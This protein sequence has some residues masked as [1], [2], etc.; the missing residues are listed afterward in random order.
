M[1]VIDKFDGTEHG[2]LSNFWLCSITFENDLYPSVENAYQAAKVPRS[3]RSR[4]LQC[5]PGESK[6]ILHGLRTNTWYA[7]R[8][9]VMTLLLTKKFAP[10][11]KLGQQLVDTGKAELIEG[12]TWN[13]T[14]WGV[15]NGV[16]EN[17]LGKLLM[18]QRDSLNAYIREL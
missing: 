14:F 2:F 18:A 10:G 16:G 5:T 12:N 4:F 17:Q 7:R 1:K 3:D 13:D 15:C 9:E 6:R 11:T 8:V